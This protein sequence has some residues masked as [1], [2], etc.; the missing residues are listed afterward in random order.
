LAGLSKDTPAS[1]QKFAA[2]LN[3]KY[4]LLADPELTLIKALGAWGEKKM[5]GKMS[6]GTIRSTFVSDGQGKL[7]LVY[8]KVKAKGHAEQILRDIA[9]RG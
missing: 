6:R 7:N 9:S 8:P 3:L 5:Y 4:P 1:H 2:K